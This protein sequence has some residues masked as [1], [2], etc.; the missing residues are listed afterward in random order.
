MSDDFKLI[1]KVIEDFQKYYTERNPD[2][3]DKIMDLFCDEG[4]LEVIGTNADK[5]GKGE[6]CLNYDSVKNLILNDWK[7]WGDLKLDLVNINIQ[8]NDKTAWFAVVGNLRN[9]FTSDEIYKDFYDYMKSTVEGE[10]EISYK[11]KLENIVRDGLECLLEVQNGEAFNWPIRVNAILVKDQDVWKF[12]QMVFS[13]PTIYP[14]IRLENN[15]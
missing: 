2:N 12:T 11:K 1:K 7:G 6:W 10:P 15:K 4:N 14:D 9:N 13:F 5:K 3:I 8:R